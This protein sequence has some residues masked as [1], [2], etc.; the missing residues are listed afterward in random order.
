ML[1]LQ[2]H[3]TSVFVLIPSNKEGKIK[4]NKNGN[5]KNLIIIHTIK[6]TDYDWH[7]LVKV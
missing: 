6:F 4:K 3:P 5:N 7:K 2:G 1:N